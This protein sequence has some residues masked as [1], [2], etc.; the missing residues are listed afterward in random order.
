VPLELG[1]RVRDRAK[2]AG[3]SRRAGE[4]RLLPLLVDL[5]PRGEHDRGQAVLRAADVVHRRLVGG[6]A[7][8]R[9]RALPRVMSRERGHRRQVEG[10]QVLHR[11]ATGHRPARRSVVTMCSGDRAMKRSLRASASTSWR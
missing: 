11:H 1:P 9:D 4:D 8:H 7:E 6:G 3:R 2:P 5:R 10:E